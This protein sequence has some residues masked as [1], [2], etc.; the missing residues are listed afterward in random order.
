MNNSQVNAK[1]TGSHRN[2]KALIYLRQSTEKQVQFNKESQ[3]L[4]YGLKDIAKE[5]G[6][7][8]IEVIDRDLGVS[9]A[10]GCS[11]RRGFEKVIGSVALGEVGILFSRETSRLSRTD[12]DWC[13]LLEVCGIFDTLISDGDQVYDLNCTDDQLVLGIKGTL[14]VVELKTLRLRMIAGMEEKAKRG[15]YKKQL[16]VGYLWNA[17][18]KIVKDPDER[19]R[20]AIEL[21]FTQFQAIGSMRQTF[22]WFHSQE[23]E[24][25]VMK[26]IG[27]RKQIVWQVPTPSQIK[28]ILQNPLYA[29]VYVWGRSRIK[30]DYVNGRVVKRK[31]KSRSASEAKTFIPDNHEGYIDLNTFTE[32]Q[33]KIRKNCLNL[34]DD[35]VVGAP[36][37]GQ[38]L[39]GGLL[40][41][42][43]CGRKFYV[44]YSGKRGTAVR[45]ICRGD[46][47][48]GGRYCLAFGGRTVDKK[49][50]A[51]LLR[52]LS[53]YGFEASLEALK[54]ASLEEEEKIQAI[55]TKIQHLEYESLRAFE[56]YNEVDPRNRLVAGELERRWNE[57]LDELEQTKK[58]LDGIAKEKVSLT[59]E[60]NQEILG[61][62]DRF[63]KV[64]E[65]CHCPNSLRKTII[66]TVIT[67]VIVTVDETEAMLKFVI[68]WQGGCHTEFEIAKPASGVGQKTD[69]EDLEIIRKM[70]P[71][72]GDADIARVLNKLGR[73]T[74]TGK[75]WTELRVRTIR[76]KY[77]MAGHILSPRNPEI[78][79]LGEAAKHL[80]VSRTTIKRLVR[81]GI[82]L[83]T[84]VVPWAP[85]EIKKSDL[86]A[87][88][89]TEIINRLRERGKLIFNGVDSKDQPFLFEEM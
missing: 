50:S 77:G 6:W 47:E 19:V 44:H 23:I 55:Q 3:R 28:G 8:E 35:E 51:E 58:R 40:R 38:S 86:D 25:P 67:E 37:E 34:K 1:I 17:E 57:K 54:Q 14:S 84:Q 20:K 74:A 43:R 88:K 64:W 12:K 45:Y 48:S 7:E 85:W 81:E 42:G 33:Q 62:G 63:S 66:R 29:G 75:R 79:T 73:R 5:W 52:V 15:E 72:Y 24:L 68:H 30:L 11:S 76:G 87:E 32:N 71:G 4:Q 70:A 65:S 21:V 60:Q 46:Y 22:L 82:L 49:F 56:Q 10:V 83:N 59:E 18:G 39:L 13:Q 80:N 16:S 69:E 53:P 27:G 78:L 26:D 41:C 89:I 9:A 31:V 61:L 2:R 36:R